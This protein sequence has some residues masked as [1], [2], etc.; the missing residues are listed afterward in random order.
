METFIIKLAVAVIPLVVLVGSVTLIT[1]MSKHYAHRPLAWHRR[2]RSVLRALS[3]G[4][5]LR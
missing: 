1:T 2:R 4:V 5:M 3:A